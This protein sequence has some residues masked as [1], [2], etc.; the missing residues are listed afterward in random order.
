MKLIAHRGNISGK[1][2]MENQ[3]D[4]LALAI[5]LGY[6]VEVDVWYVNDSLFLGHDNPEYEVDISFLMRE[7][8]WCHCKNIDALKHLLENNIHCFFH[9]SDDVALTS[10][11]II[12]TFPKKKLVEGSVCVLPELGY[13]GELDKCYAICSDFI[14]DYR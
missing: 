5:E 2:G 8:V 10:K 13:E 12:W 11:N 14:K 6:D 7:E 4:Y 9:V 3:P 1:T